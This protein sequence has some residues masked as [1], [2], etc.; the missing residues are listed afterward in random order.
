MG[1]CCKCGKETPHVYAYWSGD[2]PD[3]K[4]CANMQERVA[5]LCSR[6]ALADRVI[7]YS[8]GLA[9]WAVALV[10]HIAAK[11]DFALEVIYSVFLALYIGY[12]LFVGR[13]DKGLFYAEK[14]LAEKRIIKIMRKRNPGKIY[15]TPF[16]YKKRIRRTSP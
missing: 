3:R 1:Q 6:C 15:L 13:R 16:E 4:T 11:K 12:I 8:V 7:S 9:I 2:A 14:R 10:V 5:F